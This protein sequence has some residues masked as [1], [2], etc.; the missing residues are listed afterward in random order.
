MSVNGGL[1][2]KKIIMGG[3]VTKEKKGIMGHKKNK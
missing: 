1:N 2:N 3:M